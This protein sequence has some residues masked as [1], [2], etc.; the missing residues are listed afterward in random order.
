[1]QQCQCARFDRRLSLSTFGAGG[2]GD[3]VAR[4]QFRRLVDMNSMREGWF[5]E[6]LGLSMLASIIEYSLLTLSWSWSAASSSSSLDLDVEPTVAA[7]AAVC[8]LL[9]RR[10]GRESVLESTILAIFCTKLQ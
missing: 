7:A 10:G 5:I 1:M 8:L 6:G 4:I 9:F 2:G 3:A